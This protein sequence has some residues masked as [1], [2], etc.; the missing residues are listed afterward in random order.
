MVSVGMR[1]GGPRWF[2]S[3]L[4]AS[5]L[6]HSFMVLFSCLNLSARPPCDAPFHFMDSLTS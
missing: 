2:S 3:I 1:M 5:T 4:L 6:L